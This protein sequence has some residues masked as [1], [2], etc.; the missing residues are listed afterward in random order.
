MR[1]E[2][3][4]RKKEEGRFKEV[5]KKNKEL[6]SKKKEEG[7]NLASPNSYFILPT[8]NFSYFQL[9]S[10]SFTLIEVIVA[11]ALTAIVF[12]GIFGAYQLGLKI[13]GLSERKITA[14]QI[15]QGEIEKIRNMPYLDVG[16]VGA[17]PP[18]A[19]GTLEASTTTILNG[20]EYKIERK[21]MLIS[22][23]SDGDEECLVDY[24]RVEIK[25]SFSGILKGEVILTT[26]VMPKTKSEEL[27]ICQQQPIG[28]LSV[29]VLNAVGEFVPSPTIEVYD[30][31]GNLKGIFTPSEGKYDIPLSPGT[32]KVVVS[33]PGYST[34]RTY[35]IEEIA[36]PE[37]PNP[38]VFENQI[39][40]ISFA[41][42]KVSTMNVK[43]LSTFSEEFFS[44]SFSDE[45][46]ISQKENLIVGGGQVSLA[47]DTQGYLPSGYIF[48]VE[49]SPTNLTKWES[50]S[51]TD[52]EPE[53]TDLKYQIYF[54]SG[55]EWVLI[56]D[57]DL[58][59]NSVGFDNSPVDLSNLSTTTYSSLKLKANF[60]TNSTS[61]TPILYDWQVSWQSSN[62][63]PIPN[64]SFNL[65]GEK[66]IGRDANE[67][68]VYKYSTTT[69]T[70]SQGQI[71]ISNLEWDIYHFSNF[72]KDSQSLELATSSPSLPVSLSPDTTLDVNLYLESQ[73]S[74]LVSVFDSETLNPIFSATTTLSKTGFQETQLTNLNGQV[75]FIPLNRANYTLSIEAVGYYSTSTTVF[76]SG[77]TTKVIKLEPR[78]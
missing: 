38:T 46:K 34:E 30:S 27:A 53:N 24:K 37:K 58:P 7:S 68:P 40:Q 14:T 73:N 57:S 11:I 39:T 16:T 28:V 67:N 12:L 6:G 41:I 22:D 26:D 21:I 51:F 78:D 10:S 70:D 66:I 43:T 76:V 64:V 32:Y 72:Q 20:V 59:G 56:P 54:A 17:Q 23:P 52:E 33:K 62:P 47:T 25:V 9:P 2:V 71:Q 18:Y 50:F 55:T 60:S 77:K 45:S 36:I 5:G 69:K 8:S 29:Q 75:I 74:L 48:S 44:D 1:R 42:D 3:G 15:A 19:S 65:R 31:Q 49:I 63:T 4:I 61:Q 13:V 35:S